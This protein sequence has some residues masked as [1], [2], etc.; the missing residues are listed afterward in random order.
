MRIVIFCANGLGEFVLDSLDDSEVE[1]IA[2]ADN[3]ER[4][5]GGIM[6]VLG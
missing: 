6:Q 1:V 5:W 4:L 2:F 3:N